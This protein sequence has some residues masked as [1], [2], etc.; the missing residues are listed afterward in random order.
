MG[1]VNSR[2]STI[3]PRYRWILAVYGEG[4]RER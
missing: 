3:I 1:G 4:H 2:I